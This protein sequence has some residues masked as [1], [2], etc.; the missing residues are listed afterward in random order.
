MNPTVLKAGKYRAI[1]NIPIGWVLQALH[2]TDRSE[3]WFRL[4]IEGVSIFCVIA[5][6]HWMVGSVLQLWQIVLV[7]FVGVHTL[8]WLLTGNFWVYMLDSFSS[9]TNPGVQNIV[10][11]VERVRLSMKRLDCAETITIY[12][13]MCRSQFHIRSDLDLRIV[14]RTDSWRGFLALLGGLW[15]RVISFFLRLPV[16]LQVVDSTEFLERQMRPDERP[17]VVYERPGATVLNGGRPFDEIRA[18]PN[19]VLRA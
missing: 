15:F 2:S 5:G 16:D 3:R 4:L 7:S 10:A 18:N 8:N 17:I 11:F 14:R 9:L 12:G 19:M 13:S 1:R 6:L